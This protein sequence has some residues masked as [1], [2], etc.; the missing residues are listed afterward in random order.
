MIM[1]HDAIRHDSTTIAQEPTGVTGLDEVLCGGYLAASPTLIV[2]PPGCG[3]TLFLL[4]FLAEGAA[5]GRRVVCATCSEPPDRMAGYLRALGHPVDAWIA[6]GRLVFVDL[7]PVPGELVSGEYDLEVVKI[8]LDAAL[9]VDGRIAPGVRLGIDDLNRLAYAFDASGAARQETM[10]LLRLLRDSGVT[11]VITAGEDTSIR[12]TLAEYAVDAL[13][14]LRQTVEH[15][16]MTRMLRVLKMR[17]VGH[18]TNEYP[19]LID[20]NGPALM[21]LTGLETVYRSREG[22]ISTGHGRFDELLGGGLYRGSV[23]MVTGSSGT[24]KSTLLAQ[25]SVGLCG[26]GLTGIYLTF[27]QDQAELCHD[28]GGVG[29]DVGHWLEA[30]TLFIRRIRAVDSG[31]EEHLIRLSRFVVDERP[32]F[33]VIDSVTSLVD[34]GPLFAVKAMLLRFVDLCKASGVLLIMSELL[35]DA[36]DNV[37]TLGMSSLLDTWVRLDLVRQSGEYV[38]LI[39][40]L[41]GRGA[42]VSQQVKE[43]RISTTGIEIEDPYVGGGSF[44][45]GTDKLIRERQEQAEN[46]EQRRHLDRLNRQLEGLPKAFDARMTQIQFETEE[47]LAKLRTEIMAIQ[48]Q[49]VQIDEEAAQVKKARRG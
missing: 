38:R 11:T 15:R 48:R 26:G 29:L 4:I 14:S 34:L 21:P 31:L 43:F 46:D 20:S 22:M 1:T 49:L 47:A 30:G 27:E 42:E 44:V 6:D 8:R 12:D 41:K 45:F 18:G 17:G 40:I 3:K 32:D 13:I 5:R 23:F 10:A 24:G 16:L 35:P 33:L 39:R 9:S 28:C 7:R 19:F 37:S 36:G 2:G 25:I